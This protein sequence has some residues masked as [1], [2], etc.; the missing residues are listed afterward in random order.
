MDSTGCAQLSKLGAHQ[1]LA[2][3]WTQPIGSQTGADF[4]YRRHTDEYIYIKSDPS[5][6][7]NN[8]IDEE[9]QAALRR[10]E[11]IGDTMR[12]YYGVDGL[13]EHIDSSNL[14]IHTR[15]QGGAY[16]SFDARR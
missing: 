13:R 12:I 15:D 5:A 11:K 4:G 8:H 1:G 7:E 16:V 6:Y 9:Y 14:G 10:F 2:G 3:A